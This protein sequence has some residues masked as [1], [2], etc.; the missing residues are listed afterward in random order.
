MQNFPTYVVG[1]NFRPSEARAL[2]KRLAIGDSLYLKREPGNPYDSN[3]VMVFAQDENEDRVHIGYV[4]KDDNP[5]IAQML[6]EELEPTVEITSFAGT[7]KPAI[8]IQFSEES[9]SD[10]EEASADVGD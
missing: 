1:A 7:L 2:I 3:A 6:D 10:S 8:L 5:V 9:A 4:P